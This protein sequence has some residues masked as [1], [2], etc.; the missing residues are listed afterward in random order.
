MSEKP[1]RRGPYGKGIVK[2]K[3]STTLSNEVLESMEDEDH[4]IVKRA[5]KKRKTK[6]LHN[7][8]EPSVHNVSLNLYSDLNLIYIFADNF[9][10]SNTFCGNFLSQY[11]SPYSHKFSIY[12][13]V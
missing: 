1:Y 5:Y 12:K 9:L 8:D 10:F 13:C 7:N 3:C 6:R 11:Q 2:K 4:E